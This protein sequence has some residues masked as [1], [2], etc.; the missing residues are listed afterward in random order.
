MGEE[1]GEDADDEELSS[2]ALSEARMCF[3]TSS[4]DGNA[5]G[6]LP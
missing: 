3:S 2:S 6:P 4:G 5:I 1:E